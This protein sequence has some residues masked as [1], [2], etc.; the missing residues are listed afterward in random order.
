MLNFF[1]NKPM[2]FVSLPAPLPFLISAVKILRSSSKR[3]VLDNKEN[4]ICFY[5][6]LNLALTW[7]FLSETLWGSTERH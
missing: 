1:F 7:P 2:A 5:S 3:W 6:P 4:E